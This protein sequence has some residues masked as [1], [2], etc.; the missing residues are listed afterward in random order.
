VILL[1]VVVVV[2]QFALEV[3]TTLVMELVFVVWMEFA[4]VKEIM[5]V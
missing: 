5:L 4:H 1:I 2:K 3:Q